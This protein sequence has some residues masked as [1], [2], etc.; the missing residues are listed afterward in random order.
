MKQNKTNQNTI[1]PN[2]LPC[3]WYTQG[4]VTEDGKCNLCG[5]VL[6]TQLVKS[7][8]LHHATVVWKCVSQAGLIMVKN[9]RQWRLFFSIYFPIQ[10]CNILAIFCTSNSDCSL[11]VT[12]RNIIKYRAVTQETLRKMHRLLIPDR[13]RRSPKVM[14]CL[15]IPIHHIGIHY[16]H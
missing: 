12:S 2:S 4:E 13:G 10:S 9:I 15:R 5:T 3:T 14:T 7:N 6:I 11:W 8:Q 16:L 1:H